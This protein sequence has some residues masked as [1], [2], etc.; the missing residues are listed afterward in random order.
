MVVRFFVIG[1]YSLNFQPAQMIVT[2]SPVVQRQIPMR[3]VM[4]LYSVILTSP[5]RH[6]ILQN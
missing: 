6:Q 1:D 2:T 3:N 4:A 5:T